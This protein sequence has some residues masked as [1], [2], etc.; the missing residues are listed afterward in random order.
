V[1]TQPG[2]P[3]SFTGFFDLLRRLGITCRDTFR[4]LMNQASALRN[5]MP[6]NRPTGS[7]L[8]LAILAAIGGVL[9]LF[10]LISAL[11]G[12][13]GIFVTRSPNLVYGSC[14]ALMFGWLMMVPNLYGNIPKKGFLSLIAIYILIYLGITILLTEQ[15]TWTIVLLYA[16]VGALAYASRQLK[17]AQVT[18]ETGA[19]AADTLF[20]VTIVLI[21]VLTRSTLSQDDSLVGLV[22][23]GVTELFN[24]LSNIAST[25]ELFQQ[26][27]NTMS[28][29]I[30]P[31]LEIEYY[32]YAITSLFYLASL[33]SPM[34]RKVPPGIAAYVVSAMGVV[35][36][37]VG[38][39]GLF[40]DYS[41]NIPSLLLDLVTC[42]IGVVIAYMGLRRAAVLSTVSP[43]TTP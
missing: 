24:I 37:L 11:F 39:S 22:G 28:Q 19:C 9:G 26:V 13:L 18:D 43:S 10:G 8:H 27:L 42:G 38:L 23:L 1:S 31:N 7:D 40:Q 36:L 35:T 16:G 32:V 2:A 17:H 25:H 12:L 3:Q 33:P 41:G 20:A 29:S 30:L 14:A 15:E 4:L 21:F 6:G 5:Q 34:D